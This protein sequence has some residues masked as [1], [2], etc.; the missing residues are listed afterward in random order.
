MILAL[1]VRIKSPRKSPELV[2]AASEQL[3]HKQSPRIS[4]VGHKEVTIKTH[5]N[6]DFLG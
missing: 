2:S 6:S 5:R 4:L 3:R 1:G